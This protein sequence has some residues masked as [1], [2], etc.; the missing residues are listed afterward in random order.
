MEVRDVVLGLSNGTAESEVQLPAL[1]L[2]QLACPRR[3]LE[4][5]GEEDDMPLPE[6]FARILACNQFSLPRVNPNAAPIEVGNDTEYS[7]I[8]LLP[9]CVNHSC[10]PSV[11]RVIVRD[12]FFLR[13]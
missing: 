8:W 2:R 9:A 11:Q 3:L 4:G 13:A 7:G 10:R 6:E 12:C 1:S 5:A